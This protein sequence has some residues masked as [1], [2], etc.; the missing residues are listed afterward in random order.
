MPLAK[1]TTPLPESLAAQIESNFRK[2][3]RQP[4]TVPHP[5]VTADG[6]TPK[7]KYA[8]SVNLRLTSGKRAEFKTFFSQCEI[9]MNQGFE[10][11]VDYLI[12]EVRAGRVRLSKSGITETGD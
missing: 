9:S 6:G 12:K 10:T 8:D 3:D 2:E 5:S 7:S 11:A 4:E 1:K